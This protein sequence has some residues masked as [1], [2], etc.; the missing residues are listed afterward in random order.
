MKLSVQT[1]LDRLEPRFTD[2]LS[3]RKNKPS[4]RWTVRWQH[5]TYLQ[6]T[7]HYSW[8]LFFRLRTWSGVGTVVI[9]TVAQ[10]IIWG[11]LWHQYP[12]FFTDKH[13]HKLMIGLLSHEGI[14][15]M[16]W[17]YLFVLAFNY[18]LYL[19]ERYFWNRRAA[20]LLRE[21]I[22]LPA[23]PLAGTI[24]DPSIWPPAPIRPALK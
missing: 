17:A 2:R 23:V 14:Y 7:E 3:R 21:P 11:C 8:W 18:A 19:P 24:A 6:P 12:L 9:L 13:Y 4:P 20:R 5:E 10:V 22:A 1:I 15:Q 16:P